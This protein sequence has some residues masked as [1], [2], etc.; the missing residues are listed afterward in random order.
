MTYQVAV[1][2]LSGDHFVAAV[3]SPAEALAFLEIY[4]RE[5]VSI[6]LQTQCEVEEAYSLLR[7]MSVAAKPIDL[8][9]TSYGR[10]GGKAVV[11]C[12]T[13]DDLVLGIR[14]AL[15]GRTHEVVATANEDLY[16]AADCTMQYC[17]APGVCRPTG[18]CRHHDARTGEAQGDVREVA[19]LSGMSGY[20]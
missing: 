11:V 16:R 3:N 15:D 19:I 17:D 18:A 1:T 10:V 20:R 9:L 5:G 4:D 2:S 7:R 12:R 14:A 8:T 6:S 13:E